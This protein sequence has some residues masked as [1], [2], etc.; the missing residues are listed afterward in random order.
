MSL[1]AGITSSRMCAMPASMFD[2]C[3]WMVVERACMTHPTSIRMAPPVGATGGT[4]VLP[5]GSKNKGSV[6]YCRIGGAVIVR[7]SGPRFAGFGFDGERGVVV[8][9]FHWL[10]EHGA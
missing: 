9:H 6:R 4:T 10:G 5:C 7:R 1:S 2:V 3:A 8:G